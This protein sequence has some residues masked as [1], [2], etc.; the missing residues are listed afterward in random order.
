MLS[1][2]DFWVVIFLFGIL[3]LSQNTELFKS[4]NKA[5]PIHF[6]IDIDK[7][8]TQYITVPDDIRYVTGRCVCYTLDGR[9]PRYV[10][11]TMINCYLIREYFH[12][13]I[14][15]EV[16]YVSAAERPSNEIVSMFESLDVSVS[17][18]AVRF[19]EKDVGQID[20]NKLRGYE[21]KSFAALACRYTETLFFDADSLI[22]QDPSRFFYLPGYLE[23]GYYLHRDY[24]DCMSS[25]RESM[26]HK[27]GTTVDEFC[28]FSRGQEIDASCVIINK[29]RALLPLYVTCL[30]NLNSSLFFRERGVPT[31]FL[32]DKDTWLVGC[33]LA[34]YHP[35]VSD[36]APGFVSK[37]LPDKAERKGVAGHMQFD[38]R[39]VPLYY[40]NQV[41]NPAMT[42]LNP[43][44]DLVNDDLDLLKVYQG[45]TWKGKRYVGK[46]R[47]VAL[48]NSFIDVLEEARVAN[49]V[50][51][52]VWESSSQRTLAHG[53]RM[54]LPPIRVQ[55]SSTI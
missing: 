27:L 13:S 6:D 19:S 9:N 48:S 31:G 44:I 29:N 12:S 18:L 22:L 11:A 8:G 17:D 30:I 52:N 32:G 45:G 15:I 50:F 3:Y 51:L 28:D 14:P 20:W 1:L 25:F 23:T 41:D 55:N 24:V 5:T 4:T 53:D 35:F 36:Q 37:V 7:D 39:G 54:R 43:G 33:L 38:E 46:V 2:T 10:K 16:Y 47:E 40:N 34:G 49:Q 42:D 21:A 26:L